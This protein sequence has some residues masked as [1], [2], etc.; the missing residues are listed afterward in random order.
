MNL[1]IDFKKIMEEDEEFKNYAKNV[2]FEAFAAFNPQLIPTI[3]A[4]YQSGMTWEPAAYTL[5]MM[6]K[7]GNGNNDGNARRNS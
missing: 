1:D 4:L 7:Y 6:I 5:K 3:W 2:G